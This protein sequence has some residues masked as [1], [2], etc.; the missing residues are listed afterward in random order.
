M[1]MCRI[2]QSTWTFENAFLRIQAL[3]VFGTHS[4]AWGHRLR[5]APKAR[6][7]RAFDS[8]S[9]LG[10]A[11]YTGKASAVAFRVSRACGFGAFGPGPGRRRGGQNSSTSAGDVAR[12]R[13][14]R[15][16]RPMRC[17]CCWWTTTG[18]R[19]PWSRGCY[20]SVATKVRA[21]CAVA[22]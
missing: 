3:V 21:V 22:W 18:L 13:P 11:H 15:V 4:F 9:R 19:E 14:W 17:T 5:R 6:H 10:V 16:R 8:W 7:E 2:Y 12:P 1:D 20:G